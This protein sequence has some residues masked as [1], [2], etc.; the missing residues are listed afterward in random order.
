M[1]DKNKVRG[2]YELS[3]KKY[4]QTYLGMKSHRKSEWKT[5]YNILFYDFDKDYDK[6]FTTEYCEL[7]NTQFSN[8]NRKCLDHEHLSRYF[9][10]VCCNKCNCYLGKVDRKRMVLNLELHR[11][12]ILNNI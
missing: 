4:R 3:T 7:C 6:Y 9:R 5:K 8:K 10:F 1:D 11:Y 12:F 2:N